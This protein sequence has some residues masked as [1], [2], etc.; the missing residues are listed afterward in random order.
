LKILR[1]HQLYTKYSKC[2]FYKG[3]IQHLGHVIT[4]EVIVVD[5]KKTNTT[6]EWH[7]S[8][9]VVDIKSVLGLVR[10]YR[11]FI[12]GLSMVDYTITYL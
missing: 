7:V 10:Y 9:N 8:K 3:K 1:E 12:E 4:Q 5:P 2:E 6:M 11:C